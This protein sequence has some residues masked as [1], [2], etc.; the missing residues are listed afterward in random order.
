MPSSELNSD[1]QLCSDWFKWNDNLEF[2][3][4]FYPKGNISPT[5]CS[6]FIEQMD[7]PEVGGP[8]LTFTLAME[9]W[10]N[11]VMSHSKGGHRA[12]RQNASN[13]GFPEFA[14]IKEMEDCMDPEG[15]LI[16]HL[17]E[18]QPIGHY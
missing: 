15:N 8:P 16:L 3:L 11:P 9:N 14:T 1:E 6:L 10:C 18:L 5:Y 13:W 2:R 7:P 12:F 17:K 4:L